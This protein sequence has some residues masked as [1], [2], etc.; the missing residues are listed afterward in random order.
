[1]FA[2]LNIAPWFA[3]VASKANC[4]DGPSRFDFSYAAQVLGAA[5]VEPI[6]LTLEQLRAGPRAWIVR[7][8][9]KPKRDSGAARRARKRLNMGHTRPG[10]SPTLLDPDV[11]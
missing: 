11:E 7:A 3:Y 9:P 5:W 10:E 2:A 6:C 4:S 8:K 1:M